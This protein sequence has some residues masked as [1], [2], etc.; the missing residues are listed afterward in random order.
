[1]K[2]KVEKLTQEQLNQ[3]AIEAGKVFLI[4]EDVAEHEEEPAFGGY[5]VGYVEG[6]IRALQMIYKK[7][8]FQ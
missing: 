4:N 1:M 3:M 8:D 6:F 2:N 7:E 5:C